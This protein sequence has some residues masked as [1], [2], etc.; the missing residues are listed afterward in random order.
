MT[1]HSR[2][3]LVKFAAAF[4]LIWAGCWLT[5]R[6][7]ANIP[8]FQPVTTG[9]FQE[10]ALERYFK[11]PKPEVVIVGSSLSWHLREQFFERG[12]VR[13][14]ALPGGSPLTALAVIDAA[15]SARP[16]AIAVETNILDRSIDRNLFEKF[17]DVRRPLPPLPL[18]RTLAAWYERARPGE[19]P[20]SAEIVR[21][22]LATPPAPDR[23]K[24]SVASIW[25]DWNKDPPRQSMLDR[26]NVLKSLA[27]KLEAQGVKVF[28]FEMPYPSRVNDS[29][30]A[31]AAHEV[32]DEV[33]PPDDK[34]R[35]SLDYPLS[36]MRSEAD[37]VHLDDRSSLIFAMALDKAIQ[38]KLAEPAR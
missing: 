7:F 15:P 10:E 16:R 6:L 26:A 2:Y 22:A 19:I 28:F 36:E 5:P 13:N 25:D 24:A 4:S 29:R 30:Y 35:L 18:L 33:I 32:F 12:D 9:Q 3:W 8:Q 31:I 17:K 38:A 27:S 20:L 21:S 14:V 23:S 11:L 34:R 1:I 37:G